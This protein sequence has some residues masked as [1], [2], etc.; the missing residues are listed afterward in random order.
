MYQYNKY[1]ALFE[2][3]L[4]DIVVKSII[5]YNWLNPDEEDIILDEESIQTEKF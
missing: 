4:T 3:V 2:K 1:K 5:F